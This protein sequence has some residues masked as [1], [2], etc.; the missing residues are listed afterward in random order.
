MDK[1]NLTSEELKIVKKIEAVTEGTEKHT[2][3]N[4]VSLSPLTFEQALTGLLNS[5]PPKEKLKN[6]RSNFLWLP[7]L[8]GLQS[9]QFRFLNSL[10]V[11]RN[12]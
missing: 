6:Q 12:L 11:Y 3:E 5:P 2:S 8:L 10:T 4:P 7:K 1:S 9:I